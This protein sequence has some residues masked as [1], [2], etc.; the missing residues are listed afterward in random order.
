MKNENESFVEEVIRKVKAGEEIE[1]SLEQMENVSGGRKNI[2]GEEITP[3]LIDRYAEYMKSL[4]FNSDQV[5]LL[6][7]ALGFARVS[8]QS[9]TVAGGRDN[10]AVEQWVKIQKNLLRKDTI[11]GFASNA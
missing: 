3:E 9:I 10:C 4:K 1:L 6:S 2:Y 8:V 7:D 11:M 5:I